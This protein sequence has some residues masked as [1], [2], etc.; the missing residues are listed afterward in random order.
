VIGEEKRM[1]CC[2]MG[3]W[4][5]VV[6]V[7]I[8][9]VR[10][11][12]LEAPRRGGPDQVEARCT[13]DPGE[14]RQRFTGTLRVEMKA[15]DSKGHWLSY[16]WATNGGVIRG[17]GPAVGP[18]VELDAS[19]LNPG[20]YSVV[21]VSQ[22]AGLNRAECLVEFL[23]LPPLEPLG[24]ACR[25]ELIVLEQ[26]GVAELKVEAT[27][28]KGAPLAY[29]WFTNGG[30]LQ[31]ERRTARLDTTGLRAGDYSVTVRLQD[32][33]GQA[34]D[35][36]MLVRVLLPEYPPLPEHLASLSQVLFFFNRTTLGEMERRELTEL[37]GRVSRE[38]TGRISVEA[39]AG[40]DE[41]DP[42]NLAAARGEAVREFLIENGVAEDRV[43][44]LVGLGGRMGGKRNRTLDV[45]WVPGG[46]DY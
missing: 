31:A 35:C 4:W 40:P 30:E 28:N 20:L 1:R 26:G 6:A 19:D 14:V 21:G 2:E 45:I 25:T 7:L 18:V 12:S 13:I 16:A 9:L 34:A 27:G 10:A 17:A 5:M 3:R 46:M 24:A 41:Q 33:T 36:A 39:Y 38:S 37:A 29:H 11:G 32:S 44:V 43:M 22:D 8:C 23:V 15:T 42:Q